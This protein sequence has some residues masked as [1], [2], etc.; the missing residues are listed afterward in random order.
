[1]KEI[2]FTDLYVNAILLFCILIFSISLSL[3]ILL[4][5]DYNTV[6][7][8]ISII[9]IFFI[10]YLF[11]QKETFLPFL[12][13]T[14]IPYN[15]FNNEQYPEGS[16]LSYTID[17][18][19]YEDGTKIIYWASNNTGKIIENPYDAYKDFNNS[20]IAIVK[21]GKADVRIFCPD[22]YKVK[23]LYTMTLKKHFHYRIIDNKTGFVS[24][25]QTF[26]IDC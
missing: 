16:N 7:R 21:N 3:Y 22:K 4:N 6:L 13:T 1:M 2:F 20:G 15:L 19:D 26:Y 10:I 9:I 23:K 17:M 18:A 24:P 8:I 11:L 25:V 14:Y 12:G 5:D